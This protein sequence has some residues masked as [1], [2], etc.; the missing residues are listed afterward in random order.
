MDKMGSMGCSTVRGQ[1]LLPFVLR[2]MAAAM[3]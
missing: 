2:A 1:E 3:H